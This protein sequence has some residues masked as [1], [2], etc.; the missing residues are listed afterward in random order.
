MAGAGGNGTAAASGTEFKQG[1]E[2]VGAAA[3][4]EEASV[5]EHAAATLVS[6][7]MRGMLQLLNKA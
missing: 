5:E 6:E 7:D 2:A 4:E 1:L 3:A